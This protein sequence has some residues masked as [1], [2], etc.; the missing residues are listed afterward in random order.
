MGMDTG[1]L[2]TIEQ[3]RGK[4]MSSLVAEKLSA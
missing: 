4:T 2:F 1:A 3:I